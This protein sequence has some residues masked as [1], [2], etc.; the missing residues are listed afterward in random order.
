VGNRLQAWRHP[1]M[2]G[3]TV[4]AGI[5]IAF[6]IDAW[7]DGR[8]QSG[9]AESH[10]SALVDELEA[11]DS[12]YLT[13]LTYLD[14]HDARVTRILAE[15]E[16]Y[17]GNPLV[18][19]SLLFSLGPYATSNAPMAAFDDLEGGG[20]L[21]TIESAELRRAIAAYRRTVE[22][23]DLAEQALADYW[24]TEVMPYWDQQINTRRL[25]A[26]AAR[27]RLG[28]YL[29]EDLPPVGF[30]PNYEEVLQDRRFV[31]QLSTWAL[32][33][34][35]VRR[36]VIGVMEDNSSLRNLIASR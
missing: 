23:N 16:S 8:V 6:A 5:L 9:Q 14:L 1:V 12:V 22:R 7:W 33:V 36:S 17:S 20:G 30:D 25:A 34:A 2:E 35:R 18:M 29:A 24:S 19:D 21:A 28:P 26:I 31:N 15:A 4:L 27:G 13:M 10:L 3:L 32:Q 11:A